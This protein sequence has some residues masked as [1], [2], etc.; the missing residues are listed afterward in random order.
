MTH[1]VFISY[2]SADQK[3]VEGLSAYLEQS[4]IRCFVA[5][6][7]I[8]KG[9][10]WAEFIPPAIEN[11]KMMVYVHSSSANNSKEIDKEIAL[12]LKNHHPILPFKIQ[13]IK[14]SGAKAYHLETI[15]WLDA[16]PNPEKCFGE[17]RDDILKLIP[18]IGAKNENRKPADT[19]IPKPASQKQDNRSKSLKWAIPAAVAIV[20]IIIGA[21]LLLNRPKTPT[22]TEDG[23]N[24]TSVTHNTNSIKGVKINGVVWATCNV[25]APGTFAAKPEDPGMFYQWNRKKGWPAT[26]DVTGWDSSIPT[27][28]TWEKANDPSPAGWRVPTLDEI[29]S[30]LDTDKV[31]NEWTTENG[32]TGRKFTDKESGKRFFLP[33]V[34]FRR[35]DGT[36]YSES[37]N[38]Y[39]SSTQIDVP[40]GAY[41]LEFYNSS[42]GS[43][44]KGWGYK[45]V[46]FSVR[47]VAE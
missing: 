25:D 30:L 39:W 9:R 28:T 16:F 4:G 33:A 40:Y 14:Y 31:T 42:I 10:D 32:I 35:S 43:P 41:S 17:L 24:N 3:I 20:A 34:G 47:P 15:N 21:V 12:C 8:P 18:E 45:A 26:G 6:R 27:G 46:G 2:S 1:D 19:N 11:C 36:I 29:K 38:S 13:N 5:Y 22:A 37:S 23:N 7:D 44:E